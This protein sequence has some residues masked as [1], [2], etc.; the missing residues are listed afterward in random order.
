MKNVNVKELITEAV[1]GSGS[2]IKAME[3]NF[4]HENDSNLIERGIAKIKCSSSEAE[5]EI[6]LDKLNIEFTDAQRFEYLEF[7][8]HG[9]IYLEDKSHILVFIDSYYDT[10]D[11]ET[12]YVVIRHIKQID[13]PKELL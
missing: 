7:N 2:A 6:E 4:S 11:G 10:Y 1:K 8:V 12:K 3:L 9:T 13:I 5:K